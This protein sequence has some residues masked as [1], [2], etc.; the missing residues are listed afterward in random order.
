MVPAYRWTRDIVMETYRQQEQDNRKADTSTALLLVCPMLF[1]EELTYATIILQLKKGFLKKPHMGCMERKKQESFNGVEINFVQLRGNLL[2]LIAFWYTHEIPVGI[3]DW[4]SFVEI[5][6]FL[7]LGTR[8]YRCCFAQTSI[9]NKKKPHMQK[10]D[11][12]EP[13]AQKDHTCFAIPKSANLTRP[14]G[15]TS[16]FAPLISLHKI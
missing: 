13:A 14:F 11:S 16:M 1:I 12:Q 15:S 6:G 7:L 4:V 10:V 3:N 9:I 2:S 5:L 8:V